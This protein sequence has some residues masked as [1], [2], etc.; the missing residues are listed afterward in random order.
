[1]VGVTGLEPA[2]FPPGPKPGALPT[3]LHPEF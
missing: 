2:I 3:E 1:M